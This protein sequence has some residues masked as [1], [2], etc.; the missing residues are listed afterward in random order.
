MWNSRLPSTSNCLKSWRELDTS[1]NFY[2]VGQWFPKVGVWWKGAWNCHQFH[3]T[4]EFFADFGTFDVKVTL[5]QN[6]I[7]RR[8]RRSRRIDGQ[9]RRNEDAYLPLRGRARFFLGRESE[10]HRRGRFLDRQRGRREA[11]CLDVTG[12]SGVC[13][14]LYSSLE[15]HARAVR[16]MDWPISVRSSHRNRSSTRP[17]KMPVVWD[18]ERSSPRTPI[19]LCR[20]ER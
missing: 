15:G 4:T 9:S 18:T 2:M 6:E 13:S 19:G 17:N 1:A 10:F 12:K 11:L 7:V 14:T 3:N 16:S 8:R 5:P 20:K